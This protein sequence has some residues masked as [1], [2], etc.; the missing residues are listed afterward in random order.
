MLLR[1]LA[2]L[3]QIVAL[4]RLRNLL[5]GHNGE[6]ALVSNTCNFVPIEVVGIMIPIRHQ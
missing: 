3:R 6:A 2:R 1:A 5:I 4:L